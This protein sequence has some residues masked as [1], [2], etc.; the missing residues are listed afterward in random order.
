MEKSNGSTTQA[1]AEGTPVD[2]V[3]EWM[4]PGGETGLEE[5]MWQLTLGGGGSEPYPERPNDADCIHYLRTGFCGYGDRC[6]FNHPRD[7]ISAAIRAMRYSGEEYPERVGQPVCQYYMRTGMCKFGASCK[8]HH[9]RQRASGSP[10]AVP[11]N[12]YGCPLRPGEKECSYYIKT[13]QCKFGITCKFHHPQP[14]GLQL[15]APTAVPAPAPVVPPAVYPIVPSPIQSSQQ[16]GV[17]PGNWS[18]PRPVLFPGSYIPGTY[19]PMILPPGLVPVPGGWTAYQAPISPVASPNPQT[20]S[21]VGSVFGFSQLSSS[22]SAYPGAYVSVTSPATPSSSQKEHA[23]PQR[24]GEPECLHYM[25]TGDCKFGSSC[26]YHHPP[27]WG[28]T[29]TSFLLSPMGLPLRPGAPICSHYSQN[30]IC[31]FGLTC[32]FDHPMGTLTYSPSSSS[33]ADVPTA[34][35]PIIATPVLPPSSGLRPEG[36]SGSPNTRTHMNSDPTPCSSAKQSGSYGG[37]VSTSS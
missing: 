9:P 10:A 34:P 28:G 5:P 8:Y 13:G 27:E 11:L 7:R 26:R 1:A 3:A 36:I 22:A 18:V 14:A 30:G 6:R 12:I 23:F 35:Y 17:M 21:G 16:Y 33:I 25:R 31:N 19:S 4:V 37:E 24:P 32:K 15:P 20:N 29:R 2:P